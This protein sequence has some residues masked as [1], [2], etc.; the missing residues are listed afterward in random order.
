VSLWRKNRKQLV[1]ELGE[2]LVV[3]GEQIMEFFELPPA[4]DLPKP[5]DRVGY[6]QLAAQT[7]PVRSDRVH[8]DPRGNV[9]HCIIC[10][11]P[12]TADGRYCSICTSRI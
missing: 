8:K 2:E 7:Q 5:D 1:V 12:A 4:D 9:M 3:W 11:S 10:G 6:K